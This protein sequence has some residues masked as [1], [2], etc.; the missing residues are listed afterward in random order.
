MLIRLVKPDDLDSLVALARRASAGLTTLPADAELLARR[1]AASEAGTDPLLVMEHDDRA[2]LGTGGLCT[3]VGDPA[4]AEPFYVY[5]RQETIHRSAALGVTSRVEALHLVAEYEGPAEVGTLF[6]HPGFRGGGRGGLLSRSRFLYLAEHRDAFAPQV[7]A[8]VRGV[9]DAAGRSPFWDALGR[10][11]F[12]VDYAVADTRSARDKRFIAELMPRHPIYVPLLSHEA[13]AVLGVPHPEAVPALRALEKEGM[14]PTRMIDIF[15]AGP[16]LQCDR[17]AI[18]T[19]RT[20][21][22]ARVGRVVDH[23]DAS[24]TPDALDVI[25]ASFGDGFRATAGRLRDGGDEVTLDA[26]TAQRLEAAPGDRVRWVPARP[27]NTTATNTR[28]H[29]DA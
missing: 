28:A 21:R 20:Q 19:V 14:Y 25:I 9:V 13:Q 6:V 18:F 27:T 16:V 3:R 7:I 11:F 5:R 23:L 8:E 4:S 2:L 17:D 10:H 12:K 26:A 24:D 15:D 22:E 29:H 1:I